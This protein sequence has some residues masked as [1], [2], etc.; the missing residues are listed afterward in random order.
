MQMEQSGTARRIEILRFNK[1]T[2]GFIFKY[3]TVDYEPKGKI[4]IWYILLAVVAVIG[5]ITLIAST[6][7]DEWTIQR[8]EAIPG[9]PAKVFSYMDDLRCV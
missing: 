6:K 9:V 1:R 3:T 8:Q 5:I 7:P 4:M 2:G